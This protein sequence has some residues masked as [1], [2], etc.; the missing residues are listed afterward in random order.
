MY[1]SV[2]NAGLIS[3]NHVL[4]VDEGIL[5]AVHLEELESIL[6]EITKVGTLA[7]AVVNLVA[8]VLVAGLEQVHDGQDLSVVGHKSLT[9]GIGAGDESL[10]DLQGDGNNFVVTS[11]QSRLDR[12]DQL[13]N[14][15]QN[16]GTTVLEHVENTLNGKEAVGVHLFTDALEEDGQV[17]MVVELLDL[18]LPVDL[19]LG[20]VLNCNW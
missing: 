20:A 18:D 13:R 17:M 4:D 15:G 9:N 14:D 2:E 1:C 16:L 6:D 3:G 19:V 10:Q 11:V 5:T 7:L 12:D 8:E